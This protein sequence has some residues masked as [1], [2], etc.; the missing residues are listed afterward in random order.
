MQIAAGEAVNIGWQL[1]A[2]ALITAAEVFVSI[3]CLEFSYTQS[4]KKMKSFIMAIYLFSVSLG[5]QFVS[6][7]NHFIQ[8]PKPQIELT[9]PGQYVFSLSATDGSEQVVKEMRVNVMETKP[10]TERATAAEP[11][12]VTPPSVSFSETL[13]VTKPGES[14]NIFA[15]ADF[16]TGDGDTAYT[17]TVE[18]PSA[19]SI[20]DSKKRFSTFE[21]NAEGEYTVSLKLSVGSLD[22]EE[23]LKVLVTNDNVPPMLNLPESKDFVLYARCQGVGGI[24]DADCKEKQ[25]LSLNASGSYDPNGDELTYRVE[26]VVSTGRVIADER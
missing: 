25:T 7:F 15:S 21:A 19:A 8:N 6:F 18:G 23:S 11:D 16:G 4:P 20:A 13:L 10:K 5:N 3:T 2:Y 14:I 17:W 1:F 12:D 24:F 26:S 22:G 9:M